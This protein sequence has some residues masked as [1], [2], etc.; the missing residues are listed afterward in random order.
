MVSTFIQDYA[1]RRS[2]KTQALKQRFSPRSDDLF[3]AIPHKSIART[4]GSPILGW[5]RFAPRFPLPGS[6]L[7]NSKE[8]SLKR[9]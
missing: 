2:K 4:D 1:L 3:K 6:S 8:C 9:R 7:S 5:R